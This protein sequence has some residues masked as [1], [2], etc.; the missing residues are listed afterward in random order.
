M[1][2]L[3]SRKLYIVYPIEDQFEKSKSIEERKKENN[4]KAYFKANLDVMKQEKLLELIFW[5]GKICEFRFF[6]KWLK[7]HIIISELKISI[8]KK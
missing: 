1:V 5:L 3:L 4:L 8:L 6:L 2:N 7:I